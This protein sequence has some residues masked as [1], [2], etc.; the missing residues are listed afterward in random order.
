MLST[1]EMQT[2]SFSKHQRTTLCQPGLLTSCVTTLSLHLCICVFLTLFHWKMAALKAD[3]LH[4]AFVL[5]HQQT[6]S[7]CINLTDFHN[8]KAVRSEMNKIK[9]SL[10]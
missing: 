1:S 4:T 7:K 6:Q 3:F 2:T 9:F 8:I 10:F 5:Y